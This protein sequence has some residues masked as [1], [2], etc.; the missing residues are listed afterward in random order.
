MIDINLSP[1]TGE[2]QAIDRRR[3]MAEALQQQATTPIEQPTTPG[4]RVSP[5]AGLAKLLQGYIA[6]KNLSRADQEQKAYENSVS[7]DTARFMR[8]IGQYET[9]PG[10]IIKPAAP[11][12]I[13]PAG[14]DIEE[15]HARKNLIAYN[16]QNTK[17]G[18]RQSPTVLS[19][20][21]EG[22]N[23]FMPSSITDRII[24]EAEDLPFKTTQDVIN[25]P[26]TPEERGPSRQIPVLNAG[27]LS[28]TDPLAFKTP[29][30]RNMLAQYLMQQE[31]QKQA[32]AQRAQ[33]A[34]LQIHTAKPG[35]TAYRMGANGVPVPFLNTPAQPKWE[36]TSKFVNG[37]EVTGWVN[38]NAADIPGSFVQGTVK[39]EMT[40]PQ[41]LD[42]QLKQYAADVEAAKSQDV[43]RK[44]IQFQPLPKGVPVG[45]KHTGGKTPDGKD[46]Y[47][48]NGKKYVGD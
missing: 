13:T 37:Q 14:T 3:R 28:P 12:D 35:E 36:H 2:Q 42:A 32:A 40:E 47:E 43:G 30:I 21:K 8:N 46:V 16:L 17:D 24:K 29:Q 25:K 20:Y 26:A 48:L 10:D 39:P 5:Y 23:T 1:Y 6:G 7:E 22:E 18:M 27:L 9:V 15:N 19:P 41:R 44:S 34:A 33:E 31:A 11:A 4:V 45:A 38:T